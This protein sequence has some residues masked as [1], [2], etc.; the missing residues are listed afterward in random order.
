L[1]EADKQAVDALRHQYGTWEYL[2]GAPLPFSFGCE[3]HFSWGHIQLQL[4]AKEGVVV[5]AKVYSDAMDWS[6]PEAVETALTGCRFETS[7][8]L[9]ALRQANLQAQ[10]CEDLCKMLKKQDL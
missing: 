10:I 2:Y 9:A 1:G 5:R 4:D 3:D 8:M 7:A 6:L